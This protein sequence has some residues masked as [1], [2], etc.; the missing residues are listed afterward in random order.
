MVIFQIV[1][2]CSPFTRSLHCA[3]YLNVHLHV[4][5]YDVL[6][7]SL[8]ALCDAKKA[9][10]Q[11]QSCQKQPLSKRLSLNRLYK[12]IV[13]WR[14]GSI[15]PQHSRRFSPSPSAAE[16]H[17]SLD[18]SLKAGFIVLI[19]RHRDKWF[20]WQF[21]P[22][23][24]MMLLWAI[25]ISLSPSRSLSVSPPDPTLSTSGPAVEPGNASAT[26]MIRFSIWPMKW[27]S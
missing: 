14:L 21:E 7:G 22:L 26:E 12:W 6:P 23:Q 9:M 11:I 5:N 19:G 13:V 3:L 16:R 2:V 4:C 8:Q 20:M 17:C 15:F 1:T 27:K 25:T 18:S 10:H 24:K